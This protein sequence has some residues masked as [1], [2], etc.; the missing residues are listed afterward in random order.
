M[1]LRGAQGN[2]EDKST[3]IND[4]ND[5]HCVQAGANF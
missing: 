2:P 5:M 4:G 3:R 1:D